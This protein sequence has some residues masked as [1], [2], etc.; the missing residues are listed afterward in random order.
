MQALCRYAGSAG[1]R[2][3]EQDRAGAMLAHIGRF[4]PLHKQR[5]RL[6]NTAMGICIKPVRQHIRIMAGI[7]ALLAYGN[8]TAF[9]EQ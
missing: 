8:K 4:Y 6:A 1:I 7:E 2:G 9:F 5:I 3:A